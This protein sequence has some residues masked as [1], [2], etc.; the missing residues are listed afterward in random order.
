MPVEVRLYHPDIILFMPP[1]GFKKRCPEPV[2][3]EDGAVG[4]M[5]HFTGVKVMQQ[6]WQLF[7]R[8]FGRIRES[9]AFCRHVVRGAVHWVSFNAELKNV[10][11]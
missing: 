9:P 8:E 2:V 6:A 4:D 5:K 1:Q 10:L 11:E 7:V 3:V